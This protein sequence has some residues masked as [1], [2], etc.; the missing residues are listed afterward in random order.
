MQTLYIY[1]GA[2]TTLM[3]SGISLLCVLWVACSSFAQID[4]K[5]LRPE[6]RAPPVVAN[7]EQAIKTAKE[8]LGSTLAFEGDWSAALRPLDL[9][10]LPTN[11]AKS[12]D[13]MWYAQ[14]KSSQISG[15]Y[16]Q[17]DKVCVR[18]LLVVVRPAS[19]EVLEA[20]FDDPKA[21]VSPTPEPSLESFRRQLAGSGERWL[22]ITNDPLDRDLRAALLT[23]ARDMGGTAEAARIIIRPIWWACAREKSPFR[24]PRSVWSIDLRGTTPPPPDRPE[25]PI[26]A[27]NHIRHIV[28]ATTNKW[29]MATS[30]PQ[31][32]P[33]D[34]AVRT[35]AMKPPGVG[36]P[37]GSSA[38]NGPSPTQPNPPSSPATPPTP[39][40]PK[41]GA[42]AP[43]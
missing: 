41:P 30:V 10:V 34:P 27:R 12:G 2:K 40:A 21:V 17:E 24:A 13:T 42:S 14:A 22:G 32:D 4:P 35:P 20:V 23:V 37:P 7:A 3:S 15:L 25:W 31:P 8:F 26:E 29:L 19:G 18:N 36:A 28:D 9:N 33:P 39:D 1:H 43:R 16:P 5:V 11:V 38:P 6:Q